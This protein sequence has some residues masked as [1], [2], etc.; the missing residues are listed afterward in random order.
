MQGKERTVFTK[1]MGLEQLLREF[2][3]LEQHY[4][5][6]DRVQISEHEMEYM[7]R[8]YPSKV[9]DYLNRQ[10]SRNDI[11]IIIEYDAQY[12]YTYDKPYE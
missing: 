6:L 11:K 12:R 5:T 3:R 4:L 1:E 9:V 10:I 7:I 2:K 8:R